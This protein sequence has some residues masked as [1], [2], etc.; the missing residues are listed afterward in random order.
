MLLSSY[1]IKFGDI[2][3]KTEIQRKTLNPVWNE[4]FR[5]EVPDDSLLQDIPVELK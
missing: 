3:K 1:K 5:F 4:D 2:T